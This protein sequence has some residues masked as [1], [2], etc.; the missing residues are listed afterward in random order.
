MVSLTLFLAGNLLLSNMLFL[1]STWIYFLIFRTLVNQLASASLED[2]VWESL[3]L[4]KTKDSKSIAKAILQLLSQEDPYSETSIQVLQTLHSLAES[5][6]SHACFLIGDLY[7]TSLYGIS[8]SHDFEKR[9]SFYSK[10]E[11]AGNHT[12]I[13]RLFSLLKTLEKVCK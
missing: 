1:T 4:N 11:K 8:F 10:S 13:I 2:A 12:A 5:G 9:L 3:D 6:N 7:D